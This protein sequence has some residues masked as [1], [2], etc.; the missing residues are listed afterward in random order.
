M[1]SGWNI[2]V[3]LWLYSH[4]SWGCCHWRSISGEETSI[5]GAGS[6]SSAAWMF[7]DGRLYHTLV[8]LDVI[9]LSLGVLHVHVCT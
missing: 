9:F 8:I 7:I 5:P 3:G 2:H 1:V 6:S 4:L